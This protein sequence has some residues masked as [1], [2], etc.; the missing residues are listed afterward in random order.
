MTV[1]G[2]AKES[3]KNIVALAAVRERNALHIGWVRVMSKSGQNRLWS[4]GKHMAKAEKQNHLRPRVFHL[5]GF[6]GAKTAKTVILVHDGAD[7]AVMAYVDAYILVAGNRG[8][9]SHN[10]RVLK[11]PAGE[12][13]F[14][15]PDKILCVALGVVCKHLGG[16]IVVA[17]WPVTRFMRELA[18]L[19]RAETAELVGIDASLVTRVED[20]YQ[21]ATSGRIQEEL[22]RCLK[23]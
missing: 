2:D 6:I 4:F 10:I 11:Q 13:P 23:N 3:L 14:D 21:D 16:R 12:T 19:S 8:I 7:P 5:W 18:G 20:D 1:Q 17:P 22:L 9:P 15:L